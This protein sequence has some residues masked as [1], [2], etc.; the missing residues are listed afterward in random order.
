M[1]DSPRIEDWNYKG[2]QVFIDDEEN[3]PMIGVQKLI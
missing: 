2:L 1:Y 3:V